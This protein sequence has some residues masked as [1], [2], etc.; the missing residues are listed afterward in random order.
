MPVGVTQMTSVRAA[1]DA[2]AKTAGF[3]DSQNVPLGRAK[4][5]I[6]SVAQQTALTP[7]EVQMVL[8]NASADATEI[9]ASHLKALGTQGAY[10]GGAVHTPL[11][12]TNG[13]RP[14]AALMAAKS[15]AAA[16]VAGVKG[17]VK[18]DLNSVFHQTVEDFEAARVVL[19]KGA[20]PKT[21]REVNDACAKLLML[22]NELNGTRDDK[23][24][25]TEIVRVYKD[26][27]SQTAM[28]AKEDSCLA[29]RSF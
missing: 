25:K 15:A 2:W 28:R 9:S 18:A 29:L 14:M 19:T 5:M 20:T 4:D 26:L 17:D 12:G 10:Q 16:D 11:Q 6:S 1:A 21:V 24:V 7:M 22:F 8:M 23:Q 27:L 13:A 3:A